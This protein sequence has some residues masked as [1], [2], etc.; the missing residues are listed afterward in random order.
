MKPVYEYKNLSLEIKDLD[1]SQGVATGYFSSF[2]V[3]DAYADIV[4]PGAFAKTITEQGPNSPQPRIKHLL[5]HDT[6]LTLGKLTV[7]KE[8]SFGLYYE[9][10]LGTHSTAQDFIKMAES[11]L[12]TEHSIGYQTIKSS[13]D[14][15]TGVR[16]LIELRLMEGSSLRSWGVN[17]YTP[18]LGIK[19][20]Q[21]IE[22]MTVRLSRIEKFCRNTDATDET[23]EMLLLEVKQ[24]NQ[25]IIDLKKETTKPTVDVTQPVVKQFN[26]DYVKSQLS[27]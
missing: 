4:N 23:I 2:N 13:M 18:F 24:L 14:E 27:T 22:K 3:K 20:E 12:I 21:D 6:Y 17:Q 1:A 9:S 26:W 19:S 25:L 5:D 8:D 11:G 16:T 7:L 10:K 15:T